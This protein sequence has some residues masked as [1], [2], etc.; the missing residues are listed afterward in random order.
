LRDVA[1]AKHGLSE[2][3]RNRAKAVR[4]VAKAKNGVATAAGAARE[5]TIGPPEI[6]HDGASAKKGVRRA[7]P[8]VHLISVSE[9]DAAAVSPGHST[10]PPR[11][12]R[13]SVGGVAAGVRDVGAI[14]SR[15]RLRQPQAAR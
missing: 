15:Y 13:R 12:A 9:R 3:N 11:D 5:A 1:E 7:T 10:G 8:T 4:A 6:I 2:V 14:G